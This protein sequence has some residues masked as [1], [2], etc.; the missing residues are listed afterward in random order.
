MPQRNQVKL[1]GTVLTETETIVKY[2]CTFVSGKIVLGIEQHKNG[3][4]CFQQN[5]TSGLG[6]KI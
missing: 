6:T 4:Q 3:F 2:K 1:Q 5:A